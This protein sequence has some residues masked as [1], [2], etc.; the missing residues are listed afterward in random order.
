MG[1]RDDAEVQTIAAL[2]ALIPRVTEPALAELEALR[3]ALD[4][5]CEAITA[6]L[7]GTE[8]IDP[9]SLHEIIDRLAHAAGQ[10]ADAAG[11][12]ARSQALEE[13]RVR[14]DLARTEAQERL[15]LARAEAAAGREADRLEHAALTEALEQKKVQ[16]DA[17]RAQSEA[18]LDAARAAQT[19]LL[20]EAH[21][22]LEAAHVEAERAVAAR[23]GEIEDLRAQ[24][25]AARAEVQ[26]ASA[27]TA[28]VEQAAQ[29]RTEVLEKARARQELERAE[30]EKRLEA[31]QAEAA[32]QRERD[33]LEHVALTEAVEEG[34][35][36]VDA[37]R[38][39]AEAQLEAARAAQTQLL[40]EAHAQLEAAHVEAE[41]A[42]AARLGTHEDLEAVGRAVLSEAP[43]EAR[44]EVD[45]ERTA[46][47][48]IEAA[49][50]A[51]AEALACARKAAPAETSA[52]STTE[53]PAG[54]PV[55]AHPPDE[56]PDQ[57][58]TT[59]RTL[60]AAASLAQVL[61]ALVDGL[62]AVFPR[63]ALFVVKS[64][65]RLQGWRSVGFTG[66]AA[67]TN[68]FELSLATDSVLTRA[69]NAGRVIV[70]GDGRAPDQEP[71]A[72]AGGH[73]S[74]T[75]PVAIG[76]RVVAVV[77][78]DAGER[79]GNAAPSFDRGTALEVS[80]MLVRH[81]GRRLTALTASAQLAFGELIREAPPTTPD[82]IDAPAK[83][84]RQE[85]PP[86][87]EDA[88]R[89]AGLL[90]S[91]IKRYNEA[92]V[93]AGLPDRNLHERLKGEIERCRS[94]YARRVPPEAGATLN[95]FDEALFEILG[96]GDGGVRG[97][98]EQ[99]AGAPTTSAAP[100][101]PATAEQ[102]VSLRT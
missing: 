5:R 52:A 66:A 53:Q 90:V 70:T 87:V 20:E 49:H 78:G 14:L 3:V 10:E 76:D 34:R 13:A 7:A 43:E 85:E 55:G 80:D 33:R 22:Q 36:Q 98:F 72:G 81:A 62:G 56:T 86:R 59:V 95:C 82:A 32:A 27:E 24:L 60:D 57:L 99:T 94:L 44:T 92:N 37:I 8:R 50:A 28:R 97:P 23:L 17:I 12:A 19:Q 9:A 39:Q 1:F 21:A 46:Q 58:S 47:L 42:V 79:M 75:L 101:R 88:R 64:R 71:T 40:E 89:Y 51:Q 61:D 2:R 54:L 16:V 41:R 4:V 91:E 11:R 25:E 26:W 45:A 102:P 68:Q 73:W 67:I 15:E 35:T 18:Q 74:V 48:Q 93:L 100:D 77:H 63:A 65:S 83:R 84:A 69:V 30:A 6:A 29:V 31:V 96:G 38:A